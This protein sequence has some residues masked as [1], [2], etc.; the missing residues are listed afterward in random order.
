MSPLRSITGSLRS[1]PALIIIY[2]VLL[3]LP[4]LGVNFYNIDEVTN[5]L[6][7]N[8]ILD[9]RLGLVDFLGNTY[10]LTHYFYVLCQKIW[11]PWDL[12]PIYAVN[13]FWSLATALTLYS[14][15]KNI[16]Q[17]AQAG[18][19]AA[20][21]FLAGSVGFFSKDFRAVISEG[22]S[23]L[24]AS[25]AALC[26]IK[27]LSTA[28][29]RYAFLTGVCAGIAGLFK[30]PAIVIILA[31]WICIVIWC[32][33]RRVT[34][35]LSSLLGLMIA[36]LSPLALAP[37]LTEGWQHLSGHLSQTQ[38]LYIGVYD[39]I[40]PIYWILRYLMRTA[41]VGLAAPLIWYLATHTLRALIRGHHDTDELKTIV[42]FLFLWTLSC[43]F[44]VAL[45]K[46]VFF[47]YF[48]FLLPPLSLLAA[49]SFRE[50]FAPLTAL[51]KRVILVLSLITLLLS[52]VVFALEGR[53]GWSGKQ[54]PLA[55]LIDHIRHATKEGEQ[56]YVWGELHQ[57][58]FLSRRNPA[59][60]M[61]W[62]N[63]LAGTSPGSPAMEY[64]MTT[65]KR[66]SLVDSFQK[67]LKPSESQ[68]RTMEPLGQDD[69]NLLEAQELFSFKE[70][71]QH[72]QN[73]FWRQ[74]MI[75]F[76]RAPPTLILDT[77]PTG[78]RGYSQFP[79]EKYELLKRFITQYYSFE[80][81]IDSVMVY[82]RKGPSND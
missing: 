23:L 78:F 62:S 38:N 8:L 1:A 18:L 41:L 51:K 52:P 77:S 65:G 69:L 16:T 26:F 7:A 49:L 63:L 61:F 82:R 55:K 70:V 17:R 64:M 40:P 81:T 76:Q 13:M 24:P 32:E 59:T 2:A 57:I 4:D 19:L 43:W 72:I 66:L 67:D 53:V 9:G 10:F 60:T 35:L 71:L 5:S 75:D 11:G 3:R 39:Q 37:T 12:T 33:G 56:I 42:V 48:V 25:L 58:Y 50:F 30:A 22:L 80:K 47:H 29:N 31:A 6:F 21:C 34:M 44:V 27:S 73:P 15:A 28:P 14:I 20:L 79:I 46:R 54:P 68:K 36:T 45:G 74:V